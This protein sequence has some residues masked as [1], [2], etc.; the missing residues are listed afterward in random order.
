MTRAPP[1]DLATE[2]VLTARQRRS[3]LRFGA[4]ATALILVGPAYYGLVGIAPA[5]AAIV[6]PIVAHAIMA[7]GLLVA[8]PGTFAYAR[9]LER[10]AE[11]ATDEPVEYGV[12]DRWERENL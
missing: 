8:V 5:I 1:S 3:V 11:E 7:I 10:R 9:V 12:N 2:G 6:P 4:L